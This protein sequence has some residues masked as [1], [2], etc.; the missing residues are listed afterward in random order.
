MKSST[1][2]PEKDEVMS[3]TIHGLEATLRIR[4]I[5][6]GSPPFDIGSL[7]KSAFSFLGEWQLAMDEDGYGAAHRIATKEGIVD[8][9]GDLIT[10]VLH[11]SVPIAARGNPMTSEKMAEYRCRRTVLVQR[12]TLNAAQMFRENVSSAVLP[13]PS[14]MMKELEQIQRGRK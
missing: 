9:E 13:P 6:P 1:D 12:F 5:D 11:F 10:L 7:E 14:W 2:T 4:K 8:D 3:G